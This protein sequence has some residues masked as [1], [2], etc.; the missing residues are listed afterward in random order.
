MASVTQR[1]PN[2]LGGVS[3][4]PDDKKMLGQLRECINGYPDPTF[5]L[6][7]RPG[8]QHLHT[9]SS[10]PDAYTNAKWFYIKR[11]GTET[12]IGC[13]N[14][15]GIEIW[16]AN[17]GVVCTV[18]YENSAASYLNGSKDNYDILT[19][20]DTSI[21]V[22]NTKTVTTL[23]APSYTANTKATI[24]A[25]N[26]GYGS[27]YKVTINSS[28]Y[29][30]TTK[31]TEDP[32]L[33]NTTTTKVLS[34]EEILTTLRNGINGLGISGLTVTQLKSSLELSSS[35]AFTITASGGVSGEDIAVFQE[36]VN[37]I[38][39]LPSQ[40]THGRVVTI[41]NTA[42]KEDTYYV[43]FIAENGTSG[44][45][46]WEE[47]VKPGIST[48]LDAASMPHELLNTGLNTFTFRPLLQ[49]VSNPAR[50]FWEPRLVGDDDTNEHPSFVGQKIQKAFFHNNRLGFLTEDNVSMSQAGEYFN[51]YHVSALTTVANDPID[52]SCSSI[53]P[54][55]LKSVL[56]TAQGLV[57]F[58]ATQQFML[59]AD[60]GV[61]T[62]GTTTIRSISN[63]EIDPLISPVDVGT[64]IIFVSKI[65]GYMRVFSMQTRG[66][67]ENPEVIDIGRVISEWIPDSMDNLIASPQN[68]FISLS[69]RTSPYVYFF[70]TYGST[71]KL[72]MQS[73]FNWKLPGNVQFCTVDADNFYAVTYQAGQYT[74][75]RTNLNQTPETQILVTNEGSPVQLCMD[76]YKKPSSIV[77]DS[78]T[79]TSKC[80][81]PYND[82]TA[83]EPV[84]IIAGSVQSGFGTG[85]TV[86]PTRGT[87]GTGTYFAVQGKDLSALVNDV[88][89]GYKYN[90]DVELPRLYYQISE[91][92]SDY[93]ATL[94]IARLKFSVGLSSNVGFK[95]NR[96]GASEWYDIQSVQD[97]DYYLADDVPLARET[98]FI[99]PIHQKSDNFRIRVFSD[100]PFP[101][102][103]TSMNWEGNYSPRYYRRS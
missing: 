101:V 41:T 85:F 76:M 66:Q 6:I 22:N 39:E 31:N 5:G 62:P 71:E 78:N 34:I 88:Y 32:N 83:L 56:P 97:A 68:S 77:Y 50:F 103:L 26:A 42:G 98:V 43:Q 17:T 67:Q 89:V 9:I 28:T 64:N 29:N 99:V 57:L 11:D 74:L 80:Y 48:G 47:T 102:A 82:V 4:Q 58:T 23:A 13:I 70:R 79:E 20:Q 30:F 87:D 90:F 61:L 18:T 73:W 72:L 12:Y 1:I 21:I 7:K 63:Y 33:S 92:V 2:F 40:S 69:G 8:L 3:R 100:S 59:Y 84:L 86:T 46:Y 81:L 54:A 55:V 10:T 37:N 19:V 93:T 95:L 52:I 16:N 65:P 27:E 24:R 91:N 25:Y 49:D 45:G 75:L 60:Q 44:K 38:S 14:G 51:F 94:T 35:S 15:A 53:R 36:S 96:R